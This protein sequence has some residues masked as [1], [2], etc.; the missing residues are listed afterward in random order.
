LL[1]AN[2]TIAHT[3]VNRPIR[4]LFGTN[5]G[6]NIATNIG[7][8]I[9]TNMGMSVKYITRYVK[10]HY[11]NKKIRRDLYERLVKYCNTESI[12]VCIENIL[13]VLDNIG[14]NIATNIGTNIGTNMI[15]KTQRQDKKTISLLDLAK[16]KS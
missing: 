11:V 2:F 16:R 10:E 7:T 4:G 9:G 14:T 8:N 6:T 13:S 1:T 5:I 3:R 12:N 15:T